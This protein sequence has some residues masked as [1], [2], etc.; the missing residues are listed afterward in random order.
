MGAYSS[1]VD[2]AS[3]GSDADTADADTADA[4]SSPDLI[5]MKTSRKLPASLFSRSK[6]HESRN[7]CIAFTVV[8]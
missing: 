7:I 1:S 6:S 8:C 5:P 3:I 4:S 2:V